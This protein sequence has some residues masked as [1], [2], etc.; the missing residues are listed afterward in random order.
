MAFIQARDSDGL[1]V[2]V[3]KVSPDPLPGHTIYEENYTGAPDWGSK[4]VDVK[5]TGAETYTKE[6][7][8]LELDMRRTQHCIDIVHEFK[9]E[10]IEN[11]EKR[12][13]WSAQSMIDMTN[14]ATIQQMFSVASMGLLSSLMALTVSRPIADPIE[15]WWTQERKDALI[16]RIQEGIDEWGA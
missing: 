12:G 11:V 1:V 10:N 5:R 16:A 14:D 15:E 8:S 2:A 4:K 9:A 6:H 3:N 7:S 13:V